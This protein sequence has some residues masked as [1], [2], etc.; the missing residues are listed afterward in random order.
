MSTILEISANPS[1][2]NPTI[3]IKATSAIALIS[4]HADIFWKNNL[5]IFQKIPSEYV[6]FRNS[7]MALAFAQALPP[8][9]FHASTNFSTAL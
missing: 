2:A 5:M 6:S 9:A 4:S 7:K 3:I 8:A 1:V